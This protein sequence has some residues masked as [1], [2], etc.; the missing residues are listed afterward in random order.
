[1]YISLIIGHRG[2]GYEANLLENMGWD[3]SEVVIFDLASG[4]NELASGRNDLLKLL[5]DLKGKN[6]SVPF[7]HKNSAF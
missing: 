3:S 4:G 7:R 5:S 1:M 6:Q 2:Y